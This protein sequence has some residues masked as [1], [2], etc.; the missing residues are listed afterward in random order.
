MNEALLK[1]I[2]EKIEQSKNALIKDIQTPVC[3]LRVQGK[4]LNAETEHPVLGKLTVFTKRIDY[5][6]GFPE[7]TLNIC[8]L[9]GITAEEIAKNISK[10]ARETGVTV[11]DV[12]LRILPYARSGG[13]YAHCLSNAYVF[14]TDC[15]VP[16]TDFPIG[17]G[18]EHGVDEAASI[19]RLL[20][21]MRIYARVLL[22]LNEMEW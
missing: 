15:C 7:F 13:M 2:D 6:K 18:N 4:T 5:A 19:E 21:A 10:K 11:A 20:R 12:Q 16:P 14:G 9:L 3:I 8:Y 17:R 1:R 22:A